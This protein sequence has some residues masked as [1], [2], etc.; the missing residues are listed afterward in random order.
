MVVSLAEFETMPEKDRK[1]VLREMKSE[2]G[3]NGIT[4]AW[5]ISRSRVYNLLHELSIPLEPRKTRKGENAEKS[6]EKS[7]NSQAKREMKVNTDRSDIPS[8]RLEFEVDSPA[9]TLHLETSGNIGAISE[10]VQLLLSSGQLSSSN[11]H[12]NLTINQI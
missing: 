3:V 10:A 7:E 1:K 4:E 11:L 5:G 8:P 9:F 6:R 2:I 12:L